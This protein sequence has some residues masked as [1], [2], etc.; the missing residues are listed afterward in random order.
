MSTMQE[1]QI[2]IRTRTMVKRV[3]EKKIVALDQNKEE[4]EIPY[5]LLVRDDSI[6]PYLAK[7]S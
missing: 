5:G 7:R 1:N 2:E 3:E 4:V 6:L